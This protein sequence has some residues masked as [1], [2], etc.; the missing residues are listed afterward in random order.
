MR[1]PTNKEVNHE[2][3]FQICSSWFRALDGFGAGKRHRDLVGLLRY[4]SVY[5]SELYRWLYAAVR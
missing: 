1:L 4:Q 2:A 3:N 5:S